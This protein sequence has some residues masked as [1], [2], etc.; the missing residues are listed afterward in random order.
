MT[1][2][3]RALIDDLEV[4]LESADDGQRLQMLAEIGAVVARLEAQGHDLPAAE[5]ARLHALSE[6]Q[7]EDQFDNMPV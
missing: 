6:E 4:R 5:R 3:I 2:Q 1:D 7:V